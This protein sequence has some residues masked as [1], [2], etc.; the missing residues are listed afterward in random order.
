MIPT[1]ENISDLYLTKSGN[2]RHKTRGILYEKDACVVCGNPFLGKAKDNCC[3]REC[4]YIM[5]KNFN[6]GKKHSESTK[7]KISEKAKLRDHITRLK[8]SIDTVKEE[9][10]REG[11]VLLST[12]YINSKSKLRMVCPKGHIWESSYFNFQQG[13]R[14]YECSGKK[15][16]K[17]EWI[18]NDIESVEGY[19]LLSDTYGGAFNKL[20]IKCPKGHVFYMRYNNFQQGQRCPECNKSCVTSKG[21]KE[22]LEVVKRL[23][24]VKVVSNDKTQVLNPITN[25]YLELD[26]WIPSLRKAIEYNGEYWHR[27]NMERDTIK[28]EQCKICDIDLLTIKDKEW[29]SN[30]EYWKLYL[31]GWLNEN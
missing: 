13:N 16:R 5:T 21:E 2:L 19:E 23:I 25:R 28:I 3:S 27:K 7:Q 10:E 4:S 8:Y 20:E 6:I 14:C 26:I 9:V 30:R 1:W 15:K 18:K 11:Y 17:Y 29:K 31:M 12:E 22:V 24:N